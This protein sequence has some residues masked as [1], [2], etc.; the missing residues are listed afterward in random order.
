LYYHFYASSLFWVY[1]LRNY[2]ISE[3]RLLFLQR[4]ERKP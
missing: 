3:E 4:L 2:Q 1:R